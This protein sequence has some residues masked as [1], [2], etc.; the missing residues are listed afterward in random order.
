M[1][2]MQAARSL[3]RRQARAPMNRMDTRARII[4][5]TTVSSSNVKPRLFATSG[6]RLL[7]MF[8][9]G[10]PNV[11]QFHRLGITRSRKDLNRQD[12]KGANVQEMQIIGSSDP[13]TSIPS[14]TWR[15]WRLGV[16]NPLRLP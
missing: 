1:Q 12:A 10:N 15:T 9:G 11:S 8:V 14:V 5:M 16:S 6:G 3:P 4:A 2:R 13:S 7:F